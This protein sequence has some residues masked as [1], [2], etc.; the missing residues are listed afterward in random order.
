MTL[1]YDLRL[2]QGETFQL[3]VPVLDDNG[4]PV[5][6][7]GMSAQGQIR[8]HAAATVV[9]HEWT[10]TNGGIALDAND[11]VVKLSAA[12]T[13]A[14]TFRTGRWSLELADSDGVITRL[15]DGLVIVQPEVVR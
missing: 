15:V 12:E 4:D 2:N 1:R 14:W 10:T 8:A 11:V 7:S 6:L 3:A 13:S 9:L 5:S